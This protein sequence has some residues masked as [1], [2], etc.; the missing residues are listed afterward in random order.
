MSL[1]NVTVRLSEQG[2]DQLIRLKRITGIKNWNV[3]CRWALCLSLADSSPPLVREVQTDSNVEMS[4]RTFTGSGGAEY[5]LLVE[6]RMATTDEGFPDTYALFVAHLH[7]GIGQLA[8]MLDVRSGIE[9]L[10]ELS[11]GTER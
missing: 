8:G 2:K 5:T 1:D 11:I 9:G 10:L 3:L 6:N 4:W 7:R